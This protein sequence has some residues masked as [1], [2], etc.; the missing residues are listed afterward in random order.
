MLCGDL[1][2]QSIKVDFWSLLPDSAEAYKGYVLH[3]PFKPSSSSSGAGT[4]K[5]E[6]A[7]AGAAGAAFRR[8]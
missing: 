3:V 7:G 4:A 1:D 6:T 5:L 8:S 2:H